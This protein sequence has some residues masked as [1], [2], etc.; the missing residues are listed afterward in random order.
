VTFNAMTAAVVV[1]GVGMCI[2]IQ[3]DATPESGG[4]STRNPT[5][6]RCLLVPGNI[7]WDGCDCG[8]L[9]LTIQRNY[10]SIKFPTDTSD[11]PVGGVCHLGPR[12]VQVLASITR[13]VPALQVSIANQAIIPT[14]DSLYAAA[15]IQQG[16]AYA[17]DLAVRCCLDTF[18]K[19]RVIWDYR[20]GGVNFVGPEGACAGVELTFKFQLM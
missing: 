11:D 1:T 6:R 14:C 15:L 2:D 13:C 19:N 4:G 3:L 8:Q 17:M 18:K 7:A 10:P 9:A 5:M 20:V 16:D 12:T